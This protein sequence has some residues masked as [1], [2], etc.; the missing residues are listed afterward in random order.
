MG[1]FLMEKGDYLRGQ[2]QES[3]QKSQKP[4]RTMNYRTTLKKKNWAYSKNIPSPSSRWP[5]NICPL[6]IQN[7]Y[8]PLRAIWL[9]F[10]PFWKGVLT[11][12]VLSLPHH[13]MLGMWEHIG[14]ATPRSKTRGSSF[15]SRPDL[16]DRVLNCGPAVFPGM[17]FLE[18]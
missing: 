11:E 15:A 1:P 10:L 7:C 4:R 16:D 6:G 17:T 9:L 14:R 18:T 8:E 5:G 13:C 2:S 12:V 3:R